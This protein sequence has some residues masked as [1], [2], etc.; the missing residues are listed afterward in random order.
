[1]N[2]ESFTLFWNL[3]T[4]DS[5]LL[6]EHRFYDSP[7]GLTDYVLE[8]DIGAA[9]ILLS[10]GEN[11]GFLKGLEPRKLLSTNLERRMWKDES[12]ATW[13]PLLTNPQGT[14]CA[15]QSYNQFYLS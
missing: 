11:Y 15:N 1:M 9:K 8:E 14:M 6:E 5:F 13:N 3:A 10:K 2:G 4:K 7:E 12:L